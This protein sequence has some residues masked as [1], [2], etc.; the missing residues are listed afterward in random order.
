MG[1]THAKVPERIR[2][3]TKKMNQKYETMGIEVQ[4]EKNARKGARTHKI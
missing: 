1:Q 4:V 2:Y 3:G